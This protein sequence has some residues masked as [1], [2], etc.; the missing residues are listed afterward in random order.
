[1]S[2]QIKKRNKVIKAW[3]V[4]KDGEIISAGSYWIY[5]TKESAEMLLWRGGV[6]E[7]NREVVPCEIKLLK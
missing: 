6:K 3:S 4:V 1:M 2:K 5:S 7:K